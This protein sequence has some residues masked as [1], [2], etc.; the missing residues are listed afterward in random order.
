MSLGSVKLKI[1][2]KMT[3]IQKAVKSKKAWINSN[4][5][6]CEILMSMFLNVFFLLAFLLFIITISI[7][8]YFL[9][10]IVSLGK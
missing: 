5:L 6:L 9:L 2:V 3:K 10:S 1:D 8:I 7:I 4:K